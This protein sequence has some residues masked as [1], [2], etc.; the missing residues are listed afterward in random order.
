MNRVLTALVAAGLLVSATPA[1]AQRSRYRD[2]GTPPEYG[3]DAAAT[4]TL[5]PSAT[6]I[7]I[8]AAQVRA[9]FFASRRFE[10]EPTLGLFSSS[11]GGERF[12][13]FQFG[14]GALYHFRTLRY[15]TQPYVRGFSALQSISGSDRSTS[16]SPAL[17]IGFGAKFP[18][19]R[20]FAFRP[21]LNYDHV[22]TDGPA[23]DTDNIQLL[24]GISVFTN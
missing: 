22:W 16:T 5:D 15:E 14:V 1:H 3:I 19:G 21:E 6:V 23:D 17:G 4:F 13:Q 10:V 8:P 12:T 7:S 9:G 18:M 20:S 24:L 11:G 2:A